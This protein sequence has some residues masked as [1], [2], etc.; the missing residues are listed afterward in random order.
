MKN[1]LRWVAAVILGLVFVDFAL[2]AT[3]L[4]ML[5]GGLDVGVW[6][7][8]G[9]WAQAVLPPLGILLSVAMWIT[10]RRTE[11]QAELD[12]M[13]TDINLTER[14]GRL[15]LLNGST[16][17]IHVER[18]GEWSLVTP[19]TEFVLG[20]GATPVRFRTVAGEFW[21]VGV[22]ETSSRATPRTGATEPE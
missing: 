4:V 19:W 2:Y 3:G 5:D 6:G 15:V 18:N 13:G 1:Y 14:H 8:Y 20:L 11:R 12:R 17:A 9:E 21:E 7:T 10:D 22:N 16:H